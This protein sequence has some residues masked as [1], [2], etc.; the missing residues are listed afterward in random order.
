MARRRELGV[1]VVAGQ[2]TFD[3]LLLRAEEILGAPTEWT[4]PGVGDRDEIVQLPAG[5]V[6]STLCQV[7][8]VVAAGDGDPVIDIE[9]ADGR[10][11]RRQGDRLERSDSS[12]IFRRTGDVRQVRV[13]LAA[14]WNA[15][16]AADLDVRI[17]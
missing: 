14:S 8:I 10:T 2:I 1:A 6:G 16:L 12:M 3:G 15:D 4:V 13:T 9:F 17:P 11:E 5:A 7:P